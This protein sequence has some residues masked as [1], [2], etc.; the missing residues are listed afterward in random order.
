[1]E[2]NCKL[3][4]RSEKNYFQGYFLNLLKIQVSATFCTAIH[5]GK[6]HANHVGSVYTGDQFL[7]LKNMV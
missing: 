3:H 5:C 2:D 1:M 6:I 7:L 4:P